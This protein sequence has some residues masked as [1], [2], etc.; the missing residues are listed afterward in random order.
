MLINKQVENN[1]I[2]LLFG[3]NVIIH[4][5]IVVCH[6]GFNKIEDVHF[7]KKNGLYKEWENSHLILIINR[8]YYKMIFKKL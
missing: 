3:E 6:N 1:Q 2:V 4:F 5:I 8:L 7:V